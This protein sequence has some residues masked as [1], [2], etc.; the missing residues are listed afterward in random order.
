MLLIYLCC[1]LS[2]ASSIPSPLQHTTRAAS[3]RAKLFL[4]AGD[5]GILRV[6]AAAKFYVLSPFLFLNQCCSGEDA[7]IDMLQN[8]SIRSPLMSTVLD[9]HIGSMYAVNISESALL[10]LLQNSKRDSERLAALHCALLY[11]QH[12]EDLEMQVGKEPPLRFFQ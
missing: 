12:T 6:L 8:Y 11:F 9:C 4:T 10:H 3:T 1:G 2:L 7:R 5:L